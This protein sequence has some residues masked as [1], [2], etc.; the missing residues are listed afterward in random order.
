MISINHSFK[1]GRYGCKLYYNVYGW[2]DSP[3]YIDVS[4][5]G[6]YTASVTASS[7]LGGRITV[8][9]NEISPQAVIK[10]G[11]FVGKAIEVTATQAVFAIPPL[12]TP[13]VLAAFP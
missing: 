7:Y 5:P 11:G 2:A 3:D 13:A 1:A 8:T 6:V 10:V 12:I 4:A 9:G